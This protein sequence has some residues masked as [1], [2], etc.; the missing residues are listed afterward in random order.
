MSHPR[1]H[2]VVIMKPESV[3]TAAAIAASP[4][5]HATA[6]TPAAVPR[7]AEI[8]VILDRSGSMEAMATDAIGGFN[9]FVD[10]QRAQAGEARMT[11]V[12]FND[13]YEVPMESQPLAQIPRLTRQTY[14]P[15]GGTALLDAIGRTLRTMTEKAAA[16]PAADR[17]G[18]M[19]VAILTDGEENAS[20]EFTLPHI[21]D[22]IAEKR[23]QGWEFIF[24]AAN[25]DAIAS[26]TRLSIPMADAQAFVA[27]EAGTREA[28]SDLSAR[29]M[30]KRRKMTLHDDLEA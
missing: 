25:Q 16:R 11:L 2:A 20:R 6:P 22:L 29:L 1:W 12:L 26:A 24:L 9:A 28:F 13:R 23:A 4:A 18:S 14:A 3:P 7:T 15:R 30:E 27:S 21:S 5:S 19:I 10:A 17:P 8:A